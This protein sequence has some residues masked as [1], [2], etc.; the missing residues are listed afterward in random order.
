MCLY[1]HCVYKATPSECPVCCPCMCLSSFFCNIRM[2]A[3]CGASGVLVPWDFKAWEGYFR[4]IHEVFGG[5]NIDVWTMASHGPSGWF[6]P[7]S[8]MSH[9]KLQV[10]NV[11]LSTVLWLR[12]SLVFAIQVV[13][14]P[15]FLRSLTLSVLK[16]VS[17]IGN[18][19]NISVVD[20]ACLAG[21][22]FKLFFTWSCSLR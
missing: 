22:W 5:N 15:L 7:G 19:W 14:I 6:S 3:W 10:I 21:L 9:Q 4:A 8:W 13:F 18:I 17:S 16:E 1:G 20:T 2:I 11:S 12:G